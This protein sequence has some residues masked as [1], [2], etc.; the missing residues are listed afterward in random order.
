MTKEKARKSP[1]TKGEDSKESA[2]R[3]RRLERAKEKTLKRVQVE[4]IRKDSKSKLCKE[5]QPSLTLTLSVR[6]RELKS[7]R[8]FSRGGAQD[9][10][11]VSFRNFPIL[12]FKMLLTVEIS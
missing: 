6:Q 12:S 4:K 5:L 9:P 1:R 3:R 8:I 10:S 11:S 7:R 2:Q